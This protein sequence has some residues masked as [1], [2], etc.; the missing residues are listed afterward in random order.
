MCEFNIVLQKP[1]VVRAL[2]RRDINNIVD[3]AITK[4]RLRF[5][6]FVNQFIDEVIAVLIARDRLEKRLC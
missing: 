5:E 6:Q 3:L 2:L 1:A 4:D